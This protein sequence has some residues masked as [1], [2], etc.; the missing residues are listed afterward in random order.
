M[1][2]LPC[3]KELVHSAS[4]KTSD[5]FTEFINAR[6]KAGYPVTLRD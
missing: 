1:D 5:A 2:L 6:Q 4:S 3:L